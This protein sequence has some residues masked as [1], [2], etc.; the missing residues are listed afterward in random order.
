MFNPGTFANFRYNRKG[1]KW[2]VTSIVAP[3]FFYYKDRLA[4]EP[5]AVRAG[6]DP[7]NKPE[8]VFAILPTLNYDVTD[9]TQL[10]LGTSIDYRKQIG[11]KWSPF[12]GSL[13]NTG[14]SDR[15]RMQP[16]PVQIGVT[17][18]ITDS[19]SIFPYFRMTPIAKQRTLISS[20]TN[21]PVSKARL[22]E[23]MMFGFW[24]S[25]TLF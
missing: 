2:S 7:K 12:R 23:T 21:Q 11:S 13:Y 25:G 8:F 18:K 20:K 17:Q 1:S 9:R 14:T 4:L 5:E 15:W 10:S 16:L 22:K 24:F 3:R 19:I 6:N